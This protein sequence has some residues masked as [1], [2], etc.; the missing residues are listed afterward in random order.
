VT[1]EGRVELPV[2]LFTATVQDPQLGQQLSRDLLAVAADL[3]DG[4]DA[5]QLNGRLGRRQLRGGPSWGQGDEFVV[6]TAQGLLPLA[7]DLAGH[8]AG[9]DPD[10][11]ENRTPAR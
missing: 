5:S 9:G 10:R 3:I 7:D 1:L 8:T 11:G 6:D 2:D 4:T